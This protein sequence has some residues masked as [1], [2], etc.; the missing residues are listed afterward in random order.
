MSAVKWKLPLSQTFLIKIND[1]SWQASDDTL[2]GGIAFSASG[3]LKNNYILRVCWKV[4]QALS[5]V[6]FLMEGSVGETYI[7]LYLP[8]STIKNYKVQLSAQLPAKNWK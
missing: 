1:F 2:G 7:V 3:L 4:S 6:F 5:Q 8:V